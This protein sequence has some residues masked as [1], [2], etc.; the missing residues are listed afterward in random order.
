MERSEAQSP[1]QPEKPD[2]LGCFCLVLHS[3]V[4]YVLGH[5]TWPHGSAMAYEAAA[6]TYMPIID[7][8]QQLASEGYV[9]NLTIG[10]TPVVL[11]QLS[12]DRFKGWF[13]SYLENKIDEAHHNFEEFR[14]RGEGHLQHLAYL[15]RERY[16]SL[17]RDFTERYHR[18]LV[19][20]FR[21]LQ[22]E[23]QIEIMTSAAT[24]GYLP[25]L[26]EDGSV[27][28][29]IKE[30]ITTYNRHFGRWP[31]GFWLP[32]C[33]YRPRARW[34]VPEEI[35]S[36]GEVWMRKGLEEFLGENGIDYFIVDTHMLQGGWPL[37]VTVETD[38][39]MGKLWSRI[40]RRPV[41][42]EDRWPKDPHY[43]YFV[44]D[45]FE[46]HPPVACFARDP[47]TS[48][49]VWSAEWG[50][51]GDGWYLDFHK[52]H[53]PGGLRYW[54]ITDDSGDLAAKQQYGPEKAAERVY[55]NAG[56]FMWL[57]KETLRGCSRDFRRLPVV[58][59][60][61][62]AELFGHWW[63]EGVEWLG[64]VLRWMNQDPEIQMLT[65]HEYLR[66]HPPTSA[67]SLPEGSWG[68]GGGHWVW[69]NPETTWTWQ[70]IYDA[71]LDM[72]ALVREQGDNRDP[73]IQKFLQQAARELLL[74]QASDWQFLI[75][76]WTARDYAE[77]RLQAHHSDF[78]RVASMARRYA[79]GE[80]LTEEDW[81]YYGQ[82][83]DRDRPFHDVNPLWF[84][85]I[86]HPAI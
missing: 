31:R 26:R 47:S 68:Q 55:E 66:R 8:C 72:Q 65:C 67:I 58:C 77:F 9:A 71:E 33:A 38:Q 14:W 41:P 10:L 25:L 3:H 19:G 82:L 63:F 22:D 76:T 54:R 45:Y 20:A 27:Q 5:S 74:M 24:H 37:P 56:H 36:T 84:R 52:K 12:D 28:A 48:L 60:P 57:V 40:R 13:A 42:D 43:P 17:L 11:E 62:D 79:R 70:R 69:L 85:D 61:F 50:Y 51:P 35:G 21:E 78:K 80:W 23:G 1:Q 16:I 86:E 15:W 2:A 6:E 29:Q 4:P 53:Y 30:G 81:A 44:G 73:V 18:D 49:Q 75:T 46:D 39:T 64:Y 34:G 7:L 32:E 83:C 59:A